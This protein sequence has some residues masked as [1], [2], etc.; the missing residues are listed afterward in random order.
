MLVV[1][2]DLPD[3]DMCYYPVNP[4]RNE[5][6]KGHPAFNDEENVAFWKKASGM[7]QGLESASCKNPRK[8]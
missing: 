8:Q 7:P 6:V 4:D 1:G 5:R 3:K 2:E